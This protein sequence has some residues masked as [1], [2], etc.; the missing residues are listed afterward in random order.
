[1]NHLV[2][3]VVVLVAEDDVLIRMM[4]VDALTD[5]GFTVIEA[6]HADDALSI[7]IAQ[8][9]AVHALFTDI[10]MPGA[11]TGLD[12]A[13]HVRGK[14]P[15]IALLVASGNFRPPPTRCRSAAAFCLCPITGSCREA[16]S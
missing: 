16:R 12:L 6:V 9:K 4:V 10:Q 15:W 3:A 8:A 11:M 7:L 2:P 13:H 14:W 1:M 5:A